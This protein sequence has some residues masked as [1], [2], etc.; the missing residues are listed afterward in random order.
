MEFSHRL[1]QTKIRVNKTENKNKELLGRG[2]SDEIEVRP[3]D[4]THVAL[5]WKS[6]NLKLISPNDQ[7]PA[8]QRFYEFLATEGEAILA[9]MGF[10]PVQEQ[11]L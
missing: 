3:D 5:E 10:S 8:T 11:T 9:D 1:T 7:R 4:I 2:R 6:F